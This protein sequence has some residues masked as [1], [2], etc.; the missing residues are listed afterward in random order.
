ME[1][2]DY[3]ISL[4]SCYWSVQV[5]CSFIQFWNIIFLEI[6]QFHLGFH[7]SWHIVLHSNFLQ[8]LYFL[9]L[10]II[11]PFSRL[12]VFI[13]IFSLFFLMSLLKGLLILFVFSKNQLLDSLIF[14]IVLLVY[15]S[16]NSSLVFVISFLVLALGSLCCS[17]SSCRGRVKLFV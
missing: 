11:S 3:Y 7:I 6:C 12:I 2:F 5:F 16:F 13:W 1:I 15:M 4:I 14:R 8:S 9:V 17:M 10:V